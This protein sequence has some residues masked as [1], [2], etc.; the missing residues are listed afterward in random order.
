MSTI[1]QQLHNELSDLPI[2]RSKVNDL[3]ESID[4]LAAELDA[5]KQVMRNN[6]VVTTL[7]PLIHLCDSFKY[8]Y[9]YILY[10]SNIII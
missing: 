6:M 3:Q 9:I 1:E 8:N 7:A 2:Q 5:I 4:T 10:Y